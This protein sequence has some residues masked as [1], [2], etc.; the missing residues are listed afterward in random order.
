M[1]AL[2]IFYYNGNEFKISC[3][4]DDKMED[5]YGQ[6]IKYN[7]NKL[8]NCFLYYKERQIDLNLTFNQ[9]ADEIDKKNNCIKILVKNNNINN[10]YNSTM[11]SDDFTTCP[12]CKE[13][14][15]FEIMQDYIILKDCK[16]QHI[17]KI[18]IRDYNNKKKQN[19][20]NYIYNNSF[21]NNFSNFFANF[22]NQL[23][24]FN[25]KNIV[26]Y[27]CPLHNDYYFSYCK[28]CRS[29]LCMT[30]HNR[31]N[32]NHSII[33]F[34]TMLKN[35]EK[36]KEIFNEYNNK[37]YKMKDLIKNLNDKF[38][39]IEE[40]HKFY[41]YRMRNFNLSKKN[42]NELYNMKEIQ[43]NIKKD[44]NDIHLFSQIYDECKEIIDQI[45]IYKSNIIKEKNNSIKF[46][47]LS[48]NS[49]N[50]IY[51]DQLKISHEINFQINKAI[52]KNNS[53][54]IER[55]DEISF[56][57][58]EENNNNSK[59]LIS[60]EIYDFHI[61]KIIKKY[62]CTKF[63]KINVESIKINGTNKYKDLEIS[64][65]ITIIFE[66]NK[67]VIKTNSF[68]INK[69]DTD[70][71]NSKKE[72]KKVIQKNVYIKIE[73]IK[74]LNIVKYEDLQKESIMRINF[75]SYGTKI[76]YNESKDY[77]QNDQ[78]EF[79]LEK[80]NKIKKELGSNKLIQINNKELLV[81]NKQNKHE[82]L[83]KQ[84][85]RIYFL[86]MLNNILN[87]VKDKSYLQIF[88]QVKR[89]PN[90]NSIIEMNLFSINASHFSTFKEKY[91]QLIHYI[92]PNMK[93]GDECLVKR[94]NDIDIRLSE[95]FESRIKIF[96]LDKEVDNVEAMKSIIIQM[97][98]FPVCVA[99]L[100]VESYINI[101]ESKPIIMRKLSFNIDNILYVSIYEMSDCI[102]KRCV[103]KKV[104]HNL[105]ICEKETKSNDFFN[106]LIIIDLENNND[107]INSQNSKEKLF[108]ILS[109]FSNNEENIY[110]IYIGF[111]LFVVFLGI[112]QFYMFYFIVFCFKNNNDL[113]L[114][115]DTYLLENNFIKDISLLNN[116]RSN[117]NVLLHFYWP[118]F[119]FTFESRFKKCSFLKYLPYKTNIINLDYLFSPYN[120][121]NELNK[122]IRISKR[123]QI[124][125]NEY[126]LT[127]HYKIENL[128]KEKYNYDLINSNTCFLSKA[129]KIKS[130]CDEKYNLELNLNQSIFLNNLFV[131]HFYNIDNHTF[132]KN[133]KKNYCVITKINLFNEL[134]YIVKWNNININY[135]SF[136]KNINFNNK[137]LNVYKK[138]N[139]NIIF[140]HNNN[141]IFNSDQN[142]NNANESFIQ[143]ISCISKHSD[144][145][146]DSSIEYDCSVFKKEEDMCYIRKYY[147][148]PPN[149]NPIID[150][151]KYL[152]E[153]Y[154]CQYN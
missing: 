82:F 112:L 120:S 85:Q 131:E 33:E 52:Q 117:S 79:F 126:A 108:E 21:V 22:S 91:Y 97:N 141:L 136:R 146:E 8:N 119:P 86:L 63:L 71:I 149:K 99:S 12:R 5:V 98:F 40:K 39:K 56:I 83:D 14:C 51:I 101:K 110:F 89:Y 129:S 28:E 72:N 44:I 62:D 41:D 123:N 37:I 68:Q 107:K 17:T 81:L 4:P 25:N 74:K 50:K 65:K 121:S 24:L 111:M 76:I 106:Q 23:N 95:N 48:I 132:N 147:E 10:E 3:D 54:K 105:S 42:Y 32:N 115:N 139:F 124:D 142:D 151:E 102:K 30:C 26:N 47:N 45:N 59:L 75:S 60:N 153:N 31:H 116:P 96:P 38:D 133:E 103:I 122:N 92:F 135:Y 6:F 55:I 64:N 94:R 57:Q 148:E 13:S 53:L 100:K 93:T 114:L 118:P 16:F 49:N 84:K 58:N 35:I 29:N 18:S 113:L 144:L 154:D 2:A 125:S 11:I 130:F 20:S 134:P 87:K 43:N 34:K 9:I 140:V 61:D 27:K 127:K 143:N 138:I 137:N 77:C 90:L 78:Y 69:I 73:S 70:F 152:Y 150:Y 67:K 66:E 1:A 36:I 80:T 19:I 88:K 7:N 15:K 104:F 46:D 109:K 145:N 128:P